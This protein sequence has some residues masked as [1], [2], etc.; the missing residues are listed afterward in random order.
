VATKITLETKTLLDA[1]ATAAMWVTKKSP[2]QAL[3]CIRFT[4]ASGILEL[5][6]TDASS[7]DISLY[8]PV[9]QDGEF[10]VCIPVD[11]ILPKLQVLARSSKALT[12]TV[13]KTVTIAT[14]VHSSRIN[15]V[16]VDY[17]PELSRDFDF[18]AGT[19]VQSAEFADAIQKTV[20]A[21]DPKSPYRA[22][23]GIYMNNGDMVS[24]DGTKISLYKA[25]FVSGS[26]LVPADSLAKVARAIS[27]LDAVKIL[28]TESKF[29]V[30][31][32]GGVIVAATIGYDFPDYNSIIP[33]EHETEFV[34]DRS[35]LLDAIN[36]ATADALDSQNLITVDASGE[37]ILIQ[38]NS[39]SGGHSSKIEPESFSGPSKRFGLSVKY[40]KDALAK[41]S[42]S[43]VTFGV[44]SPSA[45]VMIYSGTEYKYGVM[46]MYVKE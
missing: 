37:T 39:S 3:Q 5:S 15:P 21:A 40:L 29:V 43:Q 16:G 26:V 8:L 34:L 33:K 13:G 30:Y 7:S 27:G 11:R 1:T 12:I 32:S 41:I 44:N 24:A 9:D 10:D 14:S 45:L 35:I 46:P 17:F 36:M 2:I 6:A 22:L 28:H 19:E 18:D 25:D 23:E 38:A 31:W 4:F 20:V 42:G